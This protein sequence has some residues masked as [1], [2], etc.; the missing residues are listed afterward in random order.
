MLSQLKKIFSIEATYLSK[1][2][3]RFLI[4]HFRFFSVFL[5][6][7]NC[8]QGN[9]SHEGSFWKP[10]GSNTVVMARRKMGLVVRA[11]AGY[12]MVGI[13]LYLEERGKPHTHFHTL[14]KH[15]QILTQT[16]L[17]NVFPCWSQINE[18]LFV[19]PIFR[20]TK[21]VVLVLNL[22][23]SDPTDL[24][25]LTLCLASTVDRAAVPSTT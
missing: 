18:W 21:P 25:A 4:K 15:R 16:S 6:S 1:R 19:S 7:G 12:G 22:S 24:A 3:K 5:R 20:F 8:L 13:S 23:F 14:A 10:T 11:I 17:S 9:N 2:D